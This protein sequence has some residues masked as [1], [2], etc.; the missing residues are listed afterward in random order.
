MNKLKIAFCTNGIFP[1]AIGGM[2][3]HSKLLIDE[4]SKHTGIDII[5]LHPHKKTLFP[6]LNVKEITIPK[7]DPAKNYLIERYRYSKQIYGHLKKLNGFIIY[8]QGP[9]VWYRAEDFKSRLIINPHGLEPFQGIT[10]RDKWIGYPFRKIYKHLFKK[11][12]YVIS[13]GGR[14]TDILKSIIAD[15]HKIII[16]PNAVEKP[17][18]QATDKTNKINK[19]FNVLFV[20]R[21]ASNKG[22]HILMQAIDKLNN[23]GF[24]NNF[25]FLLAGKG[26]LYESY[27]ASNSRPN[28]NILGFVSDKQL[29]QLYKEADLFVL[30]TLFEGMPTVILEAMSKALPIIATDV[31]AIA[32]L[33]DKSNGYLIE[34]NNVSQ[35][36]NA[37]IQFCGLTSEQKKILGEKSVQKVKNKFLWKQVALLHIKLFRKINEQ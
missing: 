22:I 34:K 1:E 10:I 9:S 5:V 8:S 14:L 23:N 29:E 35:L 17:K 12:C 13:L 24:K 4:L 7:M 33:V 2:Q 16:L 3:R 11:A 21:F 28:V 32:E 27:K 26:P 20:G 6:Q 37:L 25:E 15:K 18:L 31:G 19:P 30:P 36:K